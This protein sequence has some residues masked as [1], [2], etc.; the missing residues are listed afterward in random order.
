MKNSTLMYEFTIENQ[1]DPVPALTYY[2]VQ[3]YYDRNSNGLF[4]DS[5]TSGNEELDELD[6]FDES[7]KRVSYKELQSGIE[8]T[9]LRELPENFVG[10]V[11]WKLVVT[12]NDTGIATSDTG[13][14]YNRPDSNEVIDIDVLQIVSDRGHTYSVLGDSFTHPSGATI[15]LGLEHQYAKF[16]DNSIKV[17]DYTGKVYTTLNNNVFSG[18]KD[19]NGSVLIQYEIDASIDSATEKFWTHTYT[20]GSGAS[21]VTIDT[22]Y[23]IAFEFNPETG[24][25]GEKF[26]I[27][28]NSSEIINEH[29]EFDESY[30]ASRFPLYVPYSAGPDESSIL[31][32]HLDNKNEFTVKSNE[33][34]QLFTLQR[35][36]WVDKV[37]IYRLTG[38]SSANSTLANPVYRST[39]NAYFQYLDL[40]VDKQLFTYGALDVYGYKDGDTWNLKNVDDHTTVIYSSDKELIPVIGDVEQVLT[41]KSGVSL[42]SNKITVN[43]L[44]SFTAADR[45]TNLVQ[46]YSEMFEDL[47]DNGMYNINVETVNLFDINEWFSA[48]KDSYGYYNLGD[49]FDKE[50]AEE[51]L[52]NYDI[53]M[54][55]FTEFFGNLE[56]LNK[57]MSYELSQ[58]IVNHIDNGNSVLFA[59]DTLVTY[60]TPD[61]TNYYDENGNKYYTETSVGYAYTLMSRSYLGVDRYGLTDPEYGLSAY[62]P[63]DLRQAIVS[64]AG[65]GEENTVEIKTT[66]NASK[67]VTSRTMLGA[68]NYTANGYLNIASD[69]DALQDLVNKGYDIPIQP[70]ASAKPGD[71]PVYVEQTQGYQDIY[72]LSMDMI[73]QNDTRNADPYL[74]E[75]IKN[76]GYDQPNTTNVDQVNRGQITTFPYNINTTDFMFDE[77]KANENLVENASIPIATTHKQYYQ[78][79]MNDEELIVWFTLG[80]YKSNDMYDVMGEDAANNYY[81][82]T[83]GN[84]TYTGAGHNPYPSPIEAQLFVNTMIAS[85][86]PKVEPPKPVSVGADGEQTSTDVVLPIAS[87][88]EQLLA[89]LIAG[90]SNDNSVNKEDLAINFQI[91]SEDITGAF[92]EVFE[93]VGFEISYNGTTIS[94]RIFTRNANGTTNEITDSL[95][96]SIEPGQTY[97]MYLDDS[98]FNQLLKDLLS[99]EG[100]GVAEL[101][102]TLTTQERETGET[103]DPQSTTLSIRTYNLLELG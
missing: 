71:A 44:N 9:V 78:L 91:I 18:E 87:N 80:A 10:V 35:T 99:A 1:T 6:I 98:A 30:F 95:L 101:T 94:P 22:G 28:S 26:Y 72:V 24:D 36:D 23:V 5:D 70:N 43:N 74:I 102:L 11:P 62:I 54:I 15:D 19:F 65:Y 38:Y 60:T 4:D 83:K 46:S 51:Y 64:N 50:A 48:K 92:S 27:D 39:N 81:I 3:L 25:I 56:T 14:T 85:Y 21:E 2:T 8:Y 100:N 76:Q 47:Q 17:F 66:T 42:G 63:N 84:V 7:G 68:Q 77:E 89:A 97:T 61:G 34:M 33:D 69:P 93:V 53:V 16:Y 49:T 41:E 90:D 57:G 58:S 82:Y 40:D 88:N 96:T 75:D 37:P 79:N 20:Q 13:I 12:K 103:L 73:T 67:V 86:R 45:Y 59:H 55:G 31:A 29:S 52:E 32:A